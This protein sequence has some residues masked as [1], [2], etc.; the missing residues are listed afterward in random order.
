[1][2]SPWQLKRLDQTRLFGGLFLTKDKERQLLT[3]DPLL[4][5]GKFVAIPTIRIRDLMPGDAA[6]YSLMIRTCVG[7]WPSCYTTRGYKPSS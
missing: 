1:M 2:E 3:E 5:L 7:G 4:K 6:R